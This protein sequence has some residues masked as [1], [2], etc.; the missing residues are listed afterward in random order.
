MEKIMKTELKS[1]L[2]VPLTEVHISEPKYL[3]DNGTLKDAIGVMEK[4]NI[5]SIIVMSEKVELTGIFTERDILNK[6]IG[7]EVDL[8]S[9]ICLYMTP[10]P[11]TLRKEHTV[12]EAMELMH[13]RNFRHIPI[14]DEEK[15]PIGII[16][17]KDVMN[18]IYDLAIDQNF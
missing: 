3:I 11:K 7:K 17:I 18:F 15:R 10:H 13:S 1:R 8:D 2:K 12:L 5:G 14:V 16:S 4:F 6:V 9:P